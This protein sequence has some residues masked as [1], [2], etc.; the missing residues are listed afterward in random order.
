ITSGYLPLGAVAVSDRV[1]ETMIERAGE[2]FHGYTYSGHPLSAA[3]GL[4]TLD[5]YQDDGLFQRADELAPYWADAV[6][7]L[8][9]TRHVI[10][11]RNLGL[12]A[13]IELE[14][15]PGKPGARG[16]EAFRRCY[17]QGVLI[18]VTADIIALS[19]PL[20]IEKP[21]IDRIFE[22]IK[23]VLDALD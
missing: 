6:H 21:E 11:L 13:G 17:E 5:V 1:A 4:A 12:I 7:A 2:F 16:F 18:R 3:A 15:R 14:P 8:K 19:P 10:D 9:G 20:I 22:T 23:G